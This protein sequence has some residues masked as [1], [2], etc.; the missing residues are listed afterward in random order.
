[1]AVYTFSVKR[2]KDAVELEKTVKIPAKLEDW[3]SWRSMFHADSDDRVK[4]ILY[5]FII[6]AWVIKYQDYWRRGK[7]PNDP[8]TWKYG[9]PRLD[10]KRVIHITREEIKAKGLTRESLE[11]MKEI[12]AIDSFDEDA[13]DE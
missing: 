9:A 7:A 2:N 13:W 6:K 10:S 11:Y 12:Q 1:M 8:N 3:N 4:S 5:W